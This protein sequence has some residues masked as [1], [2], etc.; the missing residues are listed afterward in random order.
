MN[1]EQEHHAAAV[2]NYRTAADLVG[3]RAL[4]GPLERDRKHAVHAGLFL[5]LRSLMQSVL[6]LTEGIGHGEAMLA[7]TRLVMETT[8]TIRYLVMHGDQEMYD[9]FVSYGLRDEVAVLDDIQRRIDKRGTGEMPIERRMKIGIER[10]IVD[11]DATAA[12]ARSCRG[13]WG[14]NYSDR[15]KA[16]GEGPDAYLYFQRIPSAAVHGDWSNLLRF[17]LE[18]RSGGYRPA[19]NP[20]GEEQK[21]LLNPSAGMVCEAA[22][23]YARAYRPDARSLIRSLEDCIDAV[24]SAEYQS[25]DFEI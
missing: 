14:P 21:Q 1:P 13:S 15:M 9:R 5:R 2:E 10:Q 3:T 25:G 19:Y 18:K 23:A 7:L 11:S 24:R 4:L 8:I 12:A 6:C 20:S 17:H 16:I 22:I